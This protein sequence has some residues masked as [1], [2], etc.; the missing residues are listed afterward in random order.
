MRGGSG[1]VDITLFTSKKTG[2]VTK[3]TR[4]E[5]NNI[6]ATCRGFPPTTVSGTSSS[7]AQ[8]TLR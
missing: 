6:Q 5:F 4:F 3:L 7:S 2:A 1:T 8:R